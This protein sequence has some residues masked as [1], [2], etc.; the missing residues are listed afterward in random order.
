[1]KLL[2][3]L[4]GVMIIT[5]VEAAP[6]LNLIEN[7]SIS[8]GR[9]Q[10]AQN[11]FGDIVTIGANINTDI[12]S[13]ITQNFASVVAGLINDPGK[14]KKGGSFVITPDASQLKSVVDLLKSMKN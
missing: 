13:Q 4:L 8:I 5:L 1:M 11:T 7:Q 2:E 10:I 12:T 6:I 14:L 9:L 3:V